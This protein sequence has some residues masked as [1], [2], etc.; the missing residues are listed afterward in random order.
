M[1]K[2]ALGAVLGLGLVM[3]AMAQNFPDIPDNHWAYD[4]LANL[5]GKVVFGYP[6]GLYRPARP[7]SRAEFAVAINQIYQMMMAKGSS[8]DAAIAAL[9]TRI[10]NLGGGTGDVSQADFNAL[11]R[12]V[13][14]MASRLE[15]MD[16]WGNDIASLK[17]LAGEFEREL[18]GMGVDV[19]AMKKDMADLAARVSALE[20]GGVG[21]GMG[22]DISGDMNFVMINGHSTD[23]L[24]GMT[25]AGR[26]VGNARAGVPNAQGGM[27]DDMSIFH[28]LNFTFAGNAGDNVDWKASVNVNNM[29]GFASNFPGRAGFGN[30]NSQVAGASFDEQVSDVFIDEM[31]AMFDTS[32]GGQGFSA[33]VGRF[34]HSS[35]PFFLS[36]HDFTEF[37]SNDRWDDGDFVMDGA[38]LNFGFGEA[39]LTFLIAR[40]SDR[41]TV[42]GLDLNPSFLPGIG[43]LPAFND[44]TLGLEVDFDLGGASVKG[45]Y[46][47]HDSDDGAAMMLATQV[48][49]MNTFGAEVEFSFSDVDFYGVFA[50]TNFGMNTSNVLDHGNTAAAAW[51]SYDGGNWGVNGGYAK[52]QGN[53]GAFGSWGRIGTA[54]NPSNISGYGYGLWFQA[55]EDTRVNISGSSFDG[56]GA[57]FGMFGLPLTP[58]DT[59]TSMSVKLE[60]SLNDAWDVSLG[61]ENVDWNFAANPDPE[62]KWYTLG[63]NYTLSDDA[64]ISFLY[65]ISD[66]DFKNSPALFDPAGLNTY[67]G[68]VLGTQ[69]SFRF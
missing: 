16:S 44:R 2:I 45:V 67:K 17:R 10:D 58:N 69:V 64:D 65:M 63:L 27:A 48:N 32:I 14:G 52:V 51:L 39:D 21:S 13:E 20:S 62:Q 8:L 12:Q 53:F 11:K 6:D 28:E 57:A 34:R 61:F 33:E 9:N 55:S 50:Q 56:A 1:L 43:V 47:W 35:G 19:D 38:K 3:P 37:Y 60:H 59:V 24:L 30:Y 15:R 42:G 36:R 26:I 25:P 68:G 29:M 54:W 22:V 31:S 7:M 18:A 41:F 23:N 66:V 46:Y 5:K 49:R 4:A 40:N